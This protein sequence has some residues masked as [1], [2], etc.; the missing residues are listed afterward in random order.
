MFRHALTEDWTVEACRH[1]QAESDSAQ[2]REVVACARQDS[3][4][5][6]YGR[7]VASVAGAETIWVGIEEVAVSAMIAC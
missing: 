1:R 6:G 4:Q 5:G 3:A 7:E 2:G